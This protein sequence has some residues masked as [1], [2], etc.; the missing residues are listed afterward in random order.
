M[1]MSGLALFV[2]AHGCSA[3]DGGGGSGA[4][5]GSSATGGQDGSSGTGGSGTG[6]TGGIGVDSPLNDGNLTPDSACATDTY[7]AKQLP[8]A[9]LF[10]IDRSTSM[11]QAGKWTATQLAVVQAIDANSFDNLTLGLNPFPSGN[12]PGPQCILGLPVACGVSALPVVQL[13]DSGTK[14]SNDPSGVRGKIYTWMSQNQP[15]GNASPGYDALKAGIS[16]LQIFNIQGPR[17]LMLI[18]DGGFGCTSLSNPQRPAFQDAVGCLDWEHPD[19]VVQLLSAARTDPTAPV[20]TF[21]VGVPGSDTNA[22]DPDAPPFSMRRALS[23]YAMAGSPNTV[24]AGCDGSFTQAGLD[25]AVPCHF[26]LTQGN[27]NAQSLAQIIGDIRGKAL[28]C[29]YELPTAAGGQTVDKTKVNVN[30]STDGGATTKTL[31]KRSDPNDT[32]ATDG[33]WDY[34]SEGKIVLI[35]KACEDIK[36]SANAKVEI[37]V[38]CETIVK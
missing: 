23:A 21:I 29:V 20:L 9:F 5:G 32:C 35:G 27:F 38:G 11:A 31:P 15:A 26:D 22:G 3:S 17:L 30:T 8:A 12:V 14:K 34:D 19:N 7:E 6:G 25:P 1:A 33:C 4:T 36:A 24:P 18:S 2:I 28:G 16:A 10:V 37:L 13:E